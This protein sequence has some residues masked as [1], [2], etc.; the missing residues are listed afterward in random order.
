MIISEARKLQQ[1][2]KK[3]RYKIM[4][5]KRIKNGIEYQL[6]RISKKSVRNNLIV[7][8][9]LEQGALEVYMPIPDELMYIQPTE[10]FAYVRGADPIAELKIDLNLEEKTVSIQR[11]IIVEEYEDFEELEEMMLGRFSFFVSLYELEIISP[12]FDLEFLELIR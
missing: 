6:E 2:L 9:R 4:N 8:D 5:E 10:H 1:N 7:L 11:F 3:G 12:E